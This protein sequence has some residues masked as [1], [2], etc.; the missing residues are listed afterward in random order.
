MTCTCM[1]LWENRMVQSRVW[2]MRY[3]AHH[4]VLW[5]LASRQ[6]EPPRW[7]Q[8]LA[9]HR[10]RCGSTC[11]L[12]AGMATR[13]ARLPTLGGK[14]RNPR[15][16]AFVVHLA[17]PRRRGARRKFLTR[18]GLRRAGFPPVEATC[19][20]WTVRRRFLVRSR[21]WRSRRGPLAP[22][23]WVC[24]VNFVTSSDI[25]CHYPLLRSGKLATRNKDLRRFCPADARRRDEE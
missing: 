17:P 3:L 12:N 8:K 5:Q 21:I 20:K 1:H 6:A 4:D 15:F 23:Y 9:S 22:G 11:A 18:F 25:G 16:S 24:D 19:T 2:E 7:L 13:G 14:R 10:V